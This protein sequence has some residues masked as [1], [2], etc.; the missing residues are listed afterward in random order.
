M[1]TGSPAILKLKCAPLRE[2]TVFFSESTRKIYAL[3][4]FVSVRSARLVRFSGNVVA[5]L[6]LDLC[7]VY[8]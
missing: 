1:N 8:R 4:T 5:F 2:W 3:I 6:L 7:G